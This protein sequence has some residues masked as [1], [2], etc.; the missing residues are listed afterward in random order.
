MVLLCPTFWVTVLYEIYENVSSELLLATVI[1]YVPFMSVITPLVVPFS[2]ILTP[3][4][5]SLSA[6]TTVPCTF[7]CPFAA[8]HD[9]DKNMIDIRMFFILVC[10]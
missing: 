6:S 5:G 4:K 8:R 7:I 2:T 10:F 1:V 3:T 9:N